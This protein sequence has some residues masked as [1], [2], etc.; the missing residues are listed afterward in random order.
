M[1]FYRGQLPIPERKFE[2]KIGRTT[3]ESKPDK[4]VIVT[5]PE[6]APNVVVV[7]LDDVGFGGVG[8]FRW[9]RAHARAAPGS[10]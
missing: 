10:R 8:R 5:P 7:L 4:P 9:P 6:G 2:G 1:D 3:E